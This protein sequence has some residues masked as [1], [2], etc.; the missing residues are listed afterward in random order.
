M[1]DDLR[2]Y[3]SSM[4][5]PYYIEGRCAR[6]DVS[7]YTLTMETWLT[8]S[9][10]QTLRANIVPGATEELY[11]ILGQPYYYDMTWSGRNTIMISS[12]TNLTSNLKNMRTTKLVFVKDITDSPI[13]GASGY[14][15]VKIE[16][17]ISGT[18]R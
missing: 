18:T 9:Q 1:S 12:C 2:I 7:D 17:Y 16:G 8:K 13:P 11:A 3:Y 14:I 15:N 5:D 6:W 10:L 4:A